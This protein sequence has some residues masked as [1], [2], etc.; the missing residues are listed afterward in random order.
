MGNKLAR[1][2]TS[3]WSKRS[4]N[5]S[6]IIFQKA[7][8]LEI[9]SILLRS[10]WTQ[11]WK[12]G[13]NYYG[14]RW[15]E[16]CNIADVFCL[17]SARC[18]CACI[19]VNTFLIDRFSFFTSMC[20][21]KP[22]RSALGGSSHEWS[23]QESLSTRKDDYE[24]ETVMLTSNR[25]YHYQ[26]ISP[27]FTKPVAMQLRRHWTKKSFAPSGCYVDWLKRSVWSLANRKGP[28][29]PSDIRKGKE[30][31]QHRCWICGENKV[32]HIRG[33]WQSIWESNGFSKVPAEMNEI[34]RPAFVLHTRWS[35]KAPPT[36][37]WAQRP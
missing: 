3:Y 15:R 2:T 32:S 21:G 11:I 18:E 26:S 34:T 19:A 13:Y 20:A 35:E 12:L 17:A 27:A 30:I 25:Q 10:A 24:I 29:K 9:H 8:C 23:M 33:W 36:N 16:A 7:F 5:G 14:E 6:K 31:N 37:I 28:A 1:T 22:G 4:F